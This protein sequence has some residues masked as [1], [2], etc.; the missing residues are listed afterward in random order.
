MDTP[1]D[2]CCPKLAFQTIVQ[3]APQLRYLIYRNPFDGANGMPWKWFEQH[4][5]QEGTCLETVEFS[6]PPEARLYGCSARKW[7]QFQK[8]EGYASEPYPL[9]GIFE[10]VTSGSFSHKYILDVQQLWK[11]LRNMRTF[12]EPK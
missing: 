9:K 1:Q 10:K 11:K 12:H 5:L 2:K 7:L 4:M 3:N 6:P 8:V